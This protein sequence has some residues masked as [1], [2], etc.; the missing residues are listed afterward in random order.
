MGQKGELEDILRED[1]PALAFD[2]PSE[3]NLAQLSTER[4]ALAVLLIR[5][6]QSDI[7]YM[8]TLIDRAFKQ[9]REYSGSP[10][11]FLTAK[12]HSA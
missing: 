2:V 3:R 7:T 11:V 8:D 9:I 6:A 1:L 10:R 4:M 5:L 12:I